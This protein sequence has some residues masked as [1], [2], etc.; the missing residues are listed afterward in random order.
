M[1]IFFKL[2]YFRAVFPNHCAALSGVPWKMIKNFLISIIFRFYYFKSVL[3]VIVLSV[4]GFYKYFTN[5]KHSKELVTKPRNAIGSSNCQSN[6][7]T[8]PPF[9]MKCRDTQFED[10]RLLLHNARVNKELMFE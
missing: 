10:R 8:P 5:E 1:A 2:I 3:L 6:L 4:C 7:I 9:R